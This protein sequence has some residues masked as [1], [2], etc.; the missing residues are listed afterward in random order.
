MTQQTLNIARFNATFGTDAPTVMAPTVAQLP[1]FGQAVAPPEN[2]KV[3][4]DVQQK[5]KPKRI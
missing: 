5:R 1:L 2:P 4:R 3:P